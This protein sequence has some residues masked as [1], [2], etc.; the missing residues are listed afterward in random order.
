V[1]RIAEV[2]TMDVMAKLR[3]AWATAG[4]LMPDYDARVSR[5]EELHDHEQYLITKAGIKLRPEFLA[6]CKALLGEP[7]FDA[8]LSDLK[9]SQIEPAAPAITSPDGLFIFRVVEA[10]GSCASPKLPG[11]RASRV[12][13]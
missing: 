12:L 11:R 6:T 3:N 7:Q 1:L 8:I 5:P 9:R 4:R 2:E 13:R 10:L